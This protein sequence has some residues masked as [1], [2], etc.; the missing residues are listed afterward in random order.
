MLVDKPIEELQRYKGAVR[1]PVDFESFWRAT[2]HQAREKSWP[3]KLKPVDS[4]F[5][6]VEICDVQFAGFNGDPINAWLR[7]PKGV[8]DGLPVIVIYQGYNGG[9]GFAFDNIAW[10]EAGYAVFNVD[11]RGQGAGWG[12][13]DTSDSGPTGAAVAGWM[14][15]GILDKETYYYRRL[16]TDCVLAIDAVLQLD[17]IDPGR[18]GITG[19]SQGGGLSLAV[20]GLHRGIAACA[21]RVPFLCD[22]HRATDITDAYPY[23]EITDYLSVHRRDTNTVY[24]TLSYFDGVNFA[25]LAQAPLDVSLGLMDTIVPPST[26][27]AMFNN[28]A[29]PTK[30]LTVWSHNGHEGGQAEDDMRAFHFFAE[31]L[32]GRDFIE[33][34]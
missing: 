24:Q 17:M 2:L 30:T 31:H 33:E 11:T 25:R 3:I 10:V 7:Y 18:I 15:R 32:G 8:T 28:Y 23:R 12:F 20:A 13:G 34:E 27:F 21:P 29:G 4:P 1:L 19:G 22:F 14:T 6:H 16:M 9:R 26:V 5:E